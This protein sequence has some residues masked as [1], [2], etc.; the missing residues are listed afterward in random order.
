MVNSILTIRYGLR[1]HNKCCHNY[2]LDEKTLNIIGTNDTYPKNYEDY[3]LNH[4]L[5]SYG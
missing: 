1:R 4:F 5:K 3:D 2:D